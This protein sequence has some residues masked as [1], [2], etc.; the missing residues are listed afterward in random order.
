MPDRCI[1]F[2]LSTLAHIYCIDII[3]PLLLHPGEFSWQRSLCCISVCPH[4]SVGVNLC[5]PKCTNAR[6]PFIDVLISDLRRLELTAFP[7][8]KIWPI[9]TYSSCNYFPLRSFFILNK[10][11]KMS[12]LINPILNYTAS[13]LPYSSACVHF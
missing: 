3:L 12:L 6:T 7:K 5:W 4:I 2:S 9:G 10:Q 11:K 8:E 13:L 1:C